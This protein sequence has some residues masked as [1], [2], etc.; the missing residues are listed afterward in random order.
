MNLCMNTSLIEKLI[1]FDEQIISS[2]IYEHAD[3]LPRYTIAYGCYEY[4]S[5][6][7]I[8]IFCLGHFGPRI[9]LP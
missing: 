5:L 1:Y 4:K 3:A 7:S 8:D 2:V 9:D 6:R